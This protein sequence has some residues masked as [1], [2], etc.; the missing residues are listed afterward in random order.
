[1]SCD[2]F[3]HVRVRLNILFLASYHAP[4]LHG[5]D[6]GTLVLGVA[7]GREGGTGDDVEVGSIEEGE[8]VS[9]EL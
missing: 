8:I 3:G 5:N 4:E 7:E 1:L 2:K 9:D 6:A